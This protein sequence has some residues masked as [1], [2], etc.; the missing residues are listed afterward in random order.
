MAAQTA[1]YLMSQKIERLWVANRTLAHAERLV[2]ELGGEA[3][4]FEEGFDR[5]TEVDVVICSSG[6]EEA[7]ITKDRI[8]Q[9]MQARKG[10]SIF[11]IDIAV[12]CNVSR[13]VHA[14]DNVYVYNMD[15][16]QTLVQQ[17]L[18][19][20]TAEIEKAESLTETLADEFVLWLKALQD[21]REQ[22]LKH[23]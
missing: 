8:Q 4:P 11:F 18:S 21:G 14:L 9:V 19:K 20:R 16:F 6:T 3:I 1:R 13:D 7:F 15:D 23:S 17:N 12:P 5:L 10:R 2:A 22:A